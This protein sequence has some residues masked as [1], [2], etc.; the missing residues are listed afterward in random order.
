M[1][2][3]RKWTKEEDEFLKNN[4]SMTNEALQKK[5]KVDNRTLRK[6]FSELNIIRPVGRKALDKARFSIL[7]E[8]LR[9]VVPEEWFQYPL[10]RAEALEKKITFFWTG[11]PCDKCNE[12]TIRYATAGKCKPCHDLQS[13]AQKQTP[14]YKEKA[15]L[16]SQNYSQ[17]N[18]ELITQKRRDKYADPDSRQ[19]LLIQARAW[20]KRN[21]EY[22]KKH[23]RKYAIENPLDR[24]LIK[25]SRRARK[26]DAYVELNQ[27]EKNTIKELIKYMKLVNK[28]DGRISAHID[29]LLPMTKGG[30]HHPSNLQV[31]SSEANLFW[32]DKIKCCPWPKP[33]NWD[34]PVWEIEGL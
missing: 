21:P 14:E 28:R 31:I 27:E 23:N 2:N 7:R 22:F 1:V 13:K 9:D 20:R 4:F 17:V 34:E 24:K 18:A 12:P 30:L 3:K 16:Y 33:K 11:E 8:N 10:I 15:R 29:H 26:L 32:K 5:L 19:I 25:E 6:R